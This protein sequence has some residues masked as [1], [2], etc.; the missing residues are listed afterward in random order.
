[1]P[2]SVDG[3]RRSC[4]FKPMSAT[5]SPLPLPSVPWHMAQSILY[6]AAARACDSAVGFTGLVSG[7]GPACAATG[8]TGAAGSGAAAG[9]GDA[10]CAKKVA[11]VWGAV[12][13]CGISARANTGGTINRSFSMLTSRKSAEKFNSRI[14]C[15]NRVLRN[16]LFARLR[17]FHRHST[18]LLSYLYA[19]SGGSRN[20][21]CRPSHKTESYRL[22]RQNRVGYFRIEYKPCGKGI[23]PSHIQHSV[24]QS[25]RVHYLESRR[26]IS[27]CSPQKNIR[28]EMSQ[29]RH[30]R[31][32]HRGC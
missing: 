10:V 8:T 32:T 23:H 9:S 15:L 25:L 13:V 11:W 16:F 26:R 6:V 2:C 5:R 4:I 30:P 31:Q 18:P 27:K 14:P 17:G 20:M 21:V 28:R 3:S 19:A 12:T 1:M 22:I 24:P 29:C 7:T